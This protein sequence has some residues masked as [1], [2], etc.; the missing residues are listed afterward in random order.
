MKTKSFGGI[1]LTVCLLCAGILI[2][3]A[4]SYPADPEVQA[5]TY[6]LEFSAPACTTNE[7]DALKMQQWSARTVLNKPS[8]TQAEIKQAREILAIDPVKHFYALQAKGEDALA[9]LGYPAEQIRAITAFDGSEEA[10]YQACASLSTHLL[11]LNHDKSPD[12]TRT[13]EA[14]YIFAWK[15]MPSLRQTDLIA[16]S[17]DRFFYV[18]G[19]GTSTVYYA[20]DV[21]TERF[22]THP[23]VKEIPAGNGR[24]AGINVSMH[25][26]SEGTG[27]HPVCGS[28]TVKFHS[29]DFRQTCIQGIYAHA[30]LPT[31]VDPAAE[32]PL[33][34]IGTF[35]RLDVWGKFT[36]MRLDDVVAHVI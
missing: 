13:L 22:I 15:G 10:I 31:D 30:I 35:T 28:I 7:Y 17:S 32:L 27:Y 16:L 29:M 3:S 12:D 34:L 19:A 11:I 14:K 24:A 20:A 26:V 36:E 25:E 6:D 33:H 1:L 8:S 5:E 4:H 23:D 21:G 9:A 18:Q 2:A